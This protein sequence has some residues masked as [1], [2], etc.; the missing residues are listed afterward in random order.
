MVS[1]C[2]LHRVSQAVVL[3]IARNYYLTYLYSMISYYCRL[4]LYMFTVKHFVF[5]Q[6]KYEF[7]VK[8]FLQLQ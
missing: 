3:R 5:T 8:H 1:L 4:R 2:F 7:T 6:C